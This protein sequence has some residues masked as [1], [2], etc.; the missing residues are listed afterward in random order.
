MIKFILSILIVVIV[1]GLIG[2]A[3]EFSNT[4]ESWQLI[5]NKQAVSSSVQNGAISVYD[6]FKGLISDTDLG[7]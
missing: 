2:G 7:N 5:A 1:L 6:F 4:K 3:I